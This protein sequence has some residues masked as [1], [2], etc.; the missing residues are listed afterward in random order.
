M[1]PMPEQPATSVPLD[2]AIVMFDFGPTGVVRNALRIAAAS[3]KAGLL[4]ELW[5]VQDKGSLKGEVPAGIPVRTFGRPVGTRYSRGDRR[6]AGRATTPALAALLRERRP[7]VLLSAG[8]H[9]H[10]VAAGAIRQAGVSTRLLLRISTGLPR[11]VQRFNLYRWMRYHYKRRKAERR[12][13]VATRL[14]AVSEEIARELTSSTRVRAGQL[15]VIPNGIDRQR[16][17]AQAA[18]PFSHTWFE[19]GSPPVILGVGRLDKYKNFELLIA[20]FAEVRR[21]QHVRLMILGEERSAWRHRLESLAERLGVAADVRLE[22][23]QSN[24][25]PFFRRAAAYVC[26]SRYEGM[27]NAMLEAMA[28]GCPVIATRTATGATEL[29]L[30]GQLGPLAAPGVTPLANAI[31]SRLAEPRNSEQLMRRAAEYDLARTIDAYVDL[32]AREAGR[33]RVQPQA[34]GRPAKPALA[35]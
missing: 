2:V 5:V 11:P 16:I 21:R 3:A 18:L 4:T 29:L 19:P 28:N 23:F 33:R 22:G 30:D 25:H 6:R 10:S 27:S 20:A 9:F 15:L 1:G 26:C 24:P 32:L 12:Q 14:I 8:N 31:R 7:A 34:S 17:E 35:A 13:Q